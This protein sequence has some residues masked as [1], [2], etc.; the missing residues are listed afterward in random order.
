MKLVS[1]LEL[2]VIRQFGVE[3]HK[4]L[5]AT[6]EDTIYLFGIA[7]PMPWKMKF[8]AMAIPTSILI[9]E[10]GKIVWIDQSEDYRIRASEKAVMDAV[11]AN[12]AE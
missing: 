5:G 6:A 2:S 7:I 8:K 12:F 4:G 10:C 3:H 1:D 9:N 11:T